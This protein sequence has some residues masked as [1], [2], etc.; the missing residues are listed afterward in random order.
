MHSPDIPVLK[1]SARLFFEVIASGATAG[2]G[3]SA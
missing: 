1:R 2:A 3:Y